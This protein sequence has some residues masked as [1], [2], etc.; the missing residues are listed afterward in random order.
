MATSN[1]Q[2]SVFKRFKDT[3][4]VKIDPTDLEAVAW[5]KAR[6]AQLYSDAR[7]AGSL[8]AISFNS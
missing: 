1:P 7:A 2:R 6:I 5:A 8:D 3:R 4:L